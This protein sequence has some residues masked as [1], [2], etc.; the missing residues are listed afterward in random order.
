MSAY[1]ETQLENKAI[2]LSRGAKGISTTG[3][4]VTASSAK[5]DDEC[6]G[7]EPACTFDDD[8][9]F[10]EGF[11]FFLFSHPYREKNATN[12][13]MRASSL[14]GALQVISK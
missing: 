12:Q 5:N 6:V 8:P 2:C 14:V 9:R 10:A 7:I 11:F 13:R 4:G 3:R 1:A